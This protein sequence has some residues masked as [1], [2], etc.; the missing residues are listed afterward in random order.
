MINKMELLRKRWVLLDLPVLEETDGVNSVITH[1]SNVSLGIIQVA[2]TILFAG[3]EVTIL[4]FRHLTTTDDFVEAMGKIPQSEVIGLSNNYYDTFGALGVAIKT[5]RA[6]SDSVIVVGGSHVG[7]L[8]IKEEELGVDIIVRKEFEVFFQQPESRKGP[9]PLELWP[10]FKERIPVLEVTRGCFFSCEFCHHPSFEQRKL[11]D[12]ETDLAFIANYV[13]RRELVFATYLFGGARQ[14]EEKV[15]E[16]LYDQNFNFMAQGRPDLL[17]AHGWEYLQNAQ[18][19]GLC[20]LSL[21]LESVNPRT[22]LDFNKTKK[23]EKWINDTL[24]VL[25]MAKELGIKTK[26]NI[27]LFNTDSREDLKYLD[28]FLCDYEHLF[29]G[30][31]ASPLMSFPGT[32]MHGK[33]EKCDS[34]SYGASRYFSERSI[35]PVRNEHG[36]TFDEALE[37]CNVLMKRYDYYAN[38]W[39]GIN[40]KE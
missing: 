8:D 22:L 1:V 33:K 20:N 24:T 10:N 26:L 27:I 29:S 13:E 25:E 14:L 36:I 28:E 7:E 3:G 30:V 17:A 32:P 19:A 21:G 5:I 37:F 35:Y 18:N 12:I 34:L 31:T 6:T 15:F 11:K 16:L 9:H 2:K 23:P 39:D 38:L 4:D 40:A